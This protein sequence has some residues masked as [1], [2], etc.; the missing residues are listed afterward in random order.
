LLLPQVVEQA[1][2]CE[3]RLLSSWEPFY[4]KN[5]RFAKTGSDKH[6]RKSS[7]NLKERDGC[8]VR[9]RLEVAVT[10]RSP[11]EFIVAWGAGYGRRSVLFLKIDLSTT[12]PKLDLELPCS[13]R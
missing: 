7:R 5:D 11:T 8:F 3:T 10:R 4:T 12:A 9:T 13:A 6:S 2:W 1:D